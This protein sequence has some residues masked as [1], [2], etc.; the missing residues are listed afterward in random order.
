MHEWLPKTHLWCDTCWPLD[1]HYSSWAFWS[2]CLQICVLALVGLKLTTKCV[3]LPN[4]PY[5][6]GSSESYFAFWCPIA[7]DSLDILRS[8]YT[9]RQWLVLSIS[10]NTCIL[11]LLT[12]FI[13]KSKQFNQS[14]ISSH[15]LPLMLAI[16]AI[17]VNGPLSLLTCSAVNW[18]PPNDD[19]HG[20][21]PPVP[22][23]I[24]NR[25]SI[26][27]TLQNTNIESNC[28]RYLKILK[29]QIHDERT[30]SHSFLIKGISC[31]RDKC[32]ERLFR[33]NLLKVFLFF[34]TNVLCLVTLV[35]I[36]LFTKNFNGTETTLSSK[37]I[38]LYFGIRSF[39]VPVLARYMYSLSSTW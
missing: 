27:P 25:A 39:P 16:R 2:M 19:T 30:N 15:F 4:E 14:D 8:V 36:G 7:I 22:T 33:K 32:I 5:R 21:I 1:G 3:T 9:K 24:R 18:S 17:S 23:A 26:G 37:I 11:E 28:F 12:W 35:S 34:I 29:L 31:S 38:C 10:I 13:K 6:L 20:L